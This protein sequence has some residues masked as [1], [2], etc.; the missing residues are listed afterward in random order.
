M[1]WQERGGGR[2]QCRFPSYSMFKD[3][4]ILSLMQPLLYYHGNMAGP[5]S[6]GGPP[7]G[8]CWVKEAHQTSENF[9]TGGDTLFSLS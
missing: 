3:P 8:Q 9:R 4:P 1:G 2:K 5:R 6:G 7:R